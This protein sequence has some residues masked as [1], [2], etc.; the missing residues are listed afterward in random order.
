LSKTDSNPGLVLAAEN[1]GQ[2]RPKPGGTLSSPPPNLASFV[3]VT[4]DRGQ[5]PSAEKN[6]MGGC[7][8]DVPDR[9]THVAFLQH[10]GC[11]QTNVLLEISHFRQRVAKLA[12]T[13]SDCYAQRH[14]DLGHTC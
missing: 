12:I 10:F 11:Q 2:H 14:I 1:V 7:V 3:Y 6:P 9:L 8:T 5:T 4:L 13:P